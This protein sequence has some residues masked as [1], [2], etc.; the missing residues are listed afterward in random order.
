MRESFFIGD[1][2]KPAPASAP[3][4]APAPA[5]AP[6]PDAAPAVKQGQQKAMASAVK[7]PST[8]RLSVPKLG[9]SRELYSPNRGKRLAIR[10]RKAGFG[11]AAERLY[12]DWA[13]GAGGAAPSISTEAM[14]NRLLADQR[15]AAELSQMNQELIR[16]RMAK[17]LNKPE[18]INIPNLRGEKMI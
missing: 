7:R 16:R 5:P 11:N 15:Q 12:Y 1:S 10:A 13:S 18:D 4:A 3:D 17:Q 6:A 8:S 14:R 9:E 2:Q